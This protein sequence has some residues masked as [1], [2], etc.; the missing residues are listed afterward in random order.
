MDLSELNRETSDDRLT[1]L[2]IHIKSHHFRSA[3]VAASLAKRLA[4]SGQQ[5]N[6]PDKITG[7]VASTGGP[8]SLSTLISPLILRL[9]SLSVPKL[10]VPGRPA[11]GID[12]LAQISGFQSSLS[13]ED[14]KACF[15]KTGFV[16]FLA[17]DNFAPLDIRLFKIRQNTGAQSVPTLAAASL[18]SKKLALGVQ[19][20]GLDIRTADHGNFGS[21]QKTARE[22]GKMFIEAAERVNI[23]AR[24]FLTQGQLAYQPLLGR[25]E[26][27][28]ALDLLFKGEACRWLSSHYRTCEQIAFACLPENLKKNAPAIT[29]LAVL[30]VFRDT[31]MGQGGSFDSFQAIADQTR[32]NHLISV[33]AQADGYASYHLGRIRKLMTSIQNSAASVTETF[34]DPIG[35][36]LRKRPGEW[37]R[38]GEEI[39]T[40]RLESPSPGQFEAELQTLLSTTSEICVSENV[41]EIRLHG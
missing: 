33:V 39:A 8:S 28:L 32:R 17:N 21:D 2:A 30:N 3:E 37:C 1:E 12:C 23:K 27:L 41:E 16:H 38:K 31:L 9:C 22:N 7:D 26:S 29:P 40:M 14:A 18:I 19:I 25:K 5:W 36:W 4:E 24:P 34:P 11:G 6:H 13:A 15:N 20:A 10:G 35:I